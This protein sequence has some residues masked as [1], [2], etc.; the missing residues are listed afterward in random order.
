[1]RPARSR[2]SPPPGKT[3]VVLWRAPHF[4]GA[5]LLLGNVELRNLSSGGPFDVPAALI[6]LR[7]AQVHPVRDLSMGLDSRQQ[8]LV[9]GAVSDSFAR[10][11][12]PEAGS[13]C[14]YVQEEPSN[15]AYSVAC[16]KEGVL[17]GVTGQMRNAEGADWVAVTTPLGK[18]GWTK[19]AYLER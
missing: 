8:P 13:V 4:A 16:Y 10:V 19:A 15:S 5:D 18:P 3:N 2:P 6:D 9:A 14:L 11:V 1:M 17:L 7:T 12:G